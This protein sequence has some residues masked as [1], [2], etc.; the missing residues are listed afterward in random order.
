MKKTKMKKIFGFKVLLNE[1]VICRAG[2]E[3]KN[4]V[5]NCILNSIRREKDNSEELNIIIGGLNSDMNQHVNWF[6]S[7]LQ[8]GDK[9]SIEII[10]ENFDPPTTIHRSKSKKDLIDQKM[11]YYYRLKEELK[12]HLKE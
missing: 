8:E 2:F 3:N 1:K 4:A 7:S 11:E 10:S 5:V 12:D 9:I 6:D